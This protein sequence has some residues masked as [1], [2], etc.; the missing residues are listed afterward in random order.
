MRILLTLSMVLVCLLGNAQQD[1]TTAP[2]VQFKIGL[3]YNSKLHYYGRTDSLSSSGYFPMAELW[4]NNSFYVNAAPIF[5][6]NAFTG[7]DYAGS[8]TTLGYLKATPGHMVHLYAL[9]P[10]YTAESRLVQS[11]LKAQA[12]AAL[13]LFSKAINFSMG[14]DV[15]YS[16]QLDYGATAGIDHL[17]RLQKGSHLV[18]VDPT[19]S[20]NAGTQNFLR[21]YRQKKAGLLFPRE[22]TVTEKGQVFRLLA[23]EASLP[24]V[25]IKGKM[26]V[27]ATPAYVV[28]LNLQPAQTGIPAEYGKPLLYL[29]AGVKYSL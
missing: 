27:Q 3:N 28:P 9:K 16:N 1:S 2:K 6:H 18:L 4:V 12:G 14:G 26:Q 19:F 13:S 15:K 24:L 20:L 22:E 17:L 29:T 7:T 8:V 10:F 25:Y 21:T 5:V 11:A 23:W